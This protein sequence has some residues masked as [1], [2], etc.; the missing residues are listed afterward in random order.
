MLLNLFYQGPAVGKALIREYVL[1]QRLIRK[2]DIHG[3]ITD[4]RF[5]CFSA[6]IPSVFIT[7][8]INLQSPESGIP[9]WPINFSEPLV[10]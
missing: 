4:S 1:V 5:G 7:H 10:Y 8:Q 6:G 3:L 2:K 9:S